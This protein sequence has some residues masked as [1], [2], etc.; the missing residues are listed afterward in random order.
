MP[1][2]MMGLI[3]PLCPL[4]FLWLPPPVAR[5][6]TAP[7]LMLGKVGV[8]GKEFSTSLGLGH[9]R[10]QNLRGTAAWLQS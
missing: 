5:D 6:R 8:G 9:T 4:L 3:S 10:C 2:T 1:I 7:E